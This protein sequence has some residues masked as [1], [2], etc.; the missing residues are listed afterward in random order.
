M[1]DMPQ[2]LPEPARSPAGIDAHREA[3]SIHQLVLEPVSEG[4]WRLCDRA[5]AAN[6][7]GNVVAYVEVAPPD[8]FDVVWIIPG[9][10]PG[11]YRTLEQVLTD[12]T[13]LLTRPSATKPIPIAH[14]APFS[15]SRTRQP[16]AHHINP[17]GG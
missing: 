17:S 2:K 1:D 10:R 8:G 4:A 16:D 11:R 9:H 6:H 13:M 15:T 12:A 14:L 3:R 5:V 7:A